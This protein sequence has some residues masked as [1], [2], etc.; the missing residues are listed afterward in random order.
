L[1]RG[2]GSIT[3][4]YESKFAFLRNGAVSLKAEKR[5][6]ILHILNLGIR[7]SCVVRSVPG[8]GPPGSNKSVHSIS[9]KYIYSEALFYAIFFFLKKK[10]VNQEV[11]NKE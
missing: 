7:C 8:K 11:V 3:I 10:E 1:V 2:N 5:S 4:Y 6:V 9:I